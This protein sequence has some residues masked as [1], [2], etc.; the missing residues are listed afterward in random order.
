M[1]PVASPF[2]AVQQDALPKA[3]WGI[4]WNAKEQRWEA[5]AQP[6][7]PQAAL[8][9]QNKPAH[10]HHDAS[11]HEED[12]ARAQAALAALQRADS[13]GAV[14]TSTDAAVDEQQRR[15]ASA[16]PT[17]RR[18]LPPRRKSGNAARLAEAAAAEEQQDSQQV[19]CMRPSSVHHS[20]AVLP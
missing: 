12:T 14:S 10:A 18:S 19:R 9:R 7:A 1:A 3:A 2:A 5:R 4:D 16:A 20:S 15:P 6:L 8:E 11:N 13:D 17:A